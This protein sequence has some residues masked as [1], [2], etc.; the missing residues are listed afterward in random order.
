MGEPKQVEKSLVQGL[1]RIRVFLGRHGRRAVEEA[2]KHRLQFLGHATEPHPRVRVLLGID[3]DRLVGPIVVLFRGNVVEDD[4]GASVREGDP[5]LRVRVDHAPPELLEP[6][7]V[8][9]RHPVH[10]FH[11]HGV[12]VH[13]AWSRGLP[14]A[15]TPA[16]FVPSLEDRCLHAGS[17]QVGAQTEPLDSTSDDDCIVFF[18]DHLCVSF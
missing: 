13:E 3:G 6:E 7:I 14:C 4:R 18:F 11:A 1:E 8:V 12:V 17:L 16:L 9:E 5:E 10:E 15:D 2:A